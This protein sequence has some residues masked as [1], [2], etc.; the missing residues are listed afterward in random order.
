MPAEA[1][2]TPPAN[3]HLDLEVR[4][5]SNAPVG[6]CIVPLARLLLVLARRQI[7]ARDKRE[8]EVTIRDKSGP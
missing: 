2:P 7:A 4:R 6:D 1:R 3:G 8:E 5:D